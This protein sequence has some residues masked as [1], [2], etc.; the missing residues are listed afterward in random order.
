MKKI[1]INDYNIKDED[2]NEVE[3]RVKAILVNKKQEVLLGYAK[4]KYQFIGGHVEEKETL[5]ETAQRE[6]LEETGIELNIDKN[7]KPAA[8]YENYYKNK[9]S[10]NQNKKIEIYYY[11]L[12][13]DKKIN[14]NKTN[15]TEEEK[16]NNF[17]LRYIPISNLENEIIDNC[18]K[19][20]GAK[21][22]A[23]EMLEVVKRIEIKV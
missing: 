2:I 21:G 11:I 18:N 15:Y 17:E 4:N 12:K 3:T 19:Y 16:K 20:E 23:K 7:L 5:I 6:I 10:I 14:Y 8:K 22:I 1:V 13:C 9:P